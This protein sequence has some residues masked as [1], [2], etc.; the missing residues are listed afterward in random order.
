MADLENKILQQLSAQPDKAF[1]AS[2]L[3]IAI[4]GLGGKAKQLNPTLYQL[5]KEGKVSMMHNRNEAAPYWGI[6]RQLATIPEAEVPIQTFETQQIALG[7]PPVT[8]TDAQLLLQLA[9]SGSKTT[10]YNPPSINVTLPSP[11]GATAVTQM[12]NT[13]SNQISEDPI[14]KAILAYMKDVGLPL[15]PLMIAKHIFGKDAT[16]SMIN[17][18]LY[19]L[20]K[21][22]KVVHK[23]NNKG[24]N[25]SWSLL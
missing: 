4:L 18:H 1:K 9:T 16:S 20:E 19:R 24:A 12:V 25:V 11:I 13:I 2:D 15:P 21:K 8:E 10:L 17:P 3:A 5:L 23:A 14:E 6:A 22:G 7:L